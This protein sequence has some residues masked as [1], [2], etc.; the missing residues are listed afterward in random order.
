MQALGWGFPVERFAW[1]AVELGSDGVEVLPVGELPAQSVA[2]LFRA[3][4]LLQAG[5]DGFPQLGV[6]ADL[7]WLRTVATGLGT[8]LG[9]ER[10]VVP[11]DGVPTVRLRRI[12]RLTVD[13]LRLSPA[14][15][16]R[17]DA[18]SRSRSAMWMRSRSD[19]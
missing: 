16:E 13:G 14:A 3:P 15:I 17:M 18:F 1:S 12:S 2:D 8:G 19:R 5:L 6:L 10:A 4:T 9:G 7:P 11:L